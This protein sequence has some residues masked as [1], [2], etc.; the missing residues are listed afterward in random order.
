[1]LCYRDRSYCDSKDCINSFC[2]RRLTE[3]I[4]VDAE[5]VGLPICIVKMSE[6]CMAHT[7]PDKKSEI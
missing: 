6:T 3:E 4:E 7:C 2:T 1:M 5:R